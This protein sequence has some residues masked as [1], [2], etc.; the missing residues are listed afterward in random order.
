MLLASS[1]VNAAESQMFEKMKTYCFGRYLVDVPYEAEL[2]GQGNTYLSTTIKTERGSENFLRQ[3]IENRLNELKEGKTASERFLLNREIAPS[4]TSHLLIG[5]KEAF[6]SPMFSIDSFKWDQGWIFTTS[7][8]PYDNKKIDSIIARFNDY[9]KSVRYRSDREVPKG[10]GFCIE[11]G[12]IANDGKIP[13]LERASITFSLKKN[14]DVWFSI[15]TLTLSK[16]QPSILERQKAAKLDERF[17]GK[18]KSIKEG[19]RI[20]NNMQGEESLSEFPSD[21]QTGIAHN[22]IWETPGELNNPLKPMVSLEM[23]SGEGVAGV[24]GVSSMSTKQIQA[25]YEAI[26]KTIRLRPTTETR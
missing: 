8:G 11:N 23:T 6:G 26:V 18:I 13:Q 15:D 22:L 17:S 3:K 4:K 2:K 16:N 1:S 21:D 5:Y 25:L 19:I 12:F 10:A 9:L 14:P 20:V 7:R 24:T